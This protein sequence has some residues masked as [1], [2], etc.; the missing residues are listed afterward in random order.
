MA[1]AQDETTIGAEPTAEG[2]SA[3]EA[4]AE[5]PSAEEAPAEA[6]AET[7]PADAG[8]SDAGPSSAPDHGLLGPLRIGP[9]FAAGLP[10]PMNYGLDALYDRTWGFAFG[11]GKLT[12][13]MGKVEAQLANWDV[14]ARWHPGKGSFFWGL[15]YGQQTILVEAEQ[16][17]KFKQ[18]ELDIVVPATLQMTVESTYVTP[19]F[20]WFAMW[21]S[22]F[23]LGFELGA[24]IPMSSE[25]DLEVG[26][27][28]VSPS[29]EA[30][31]KKRDEYTKLEKTV[32]DAGKL[33]GDTVLPYLTLI[34]LGWMF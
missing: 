18:S 21:D 6:P 31:I 22:G 16:D 2:Q 20:G 28:N 23:T 19:H 33:L 15:A 29:Q 9:T 32:E 5:T 26:L 3:S 10:H 27:Q 34:R 30:E 12:L 14:R 1:L 17:L 25:S 7:P 11:T 8:P 24:Q 13:P 4:D